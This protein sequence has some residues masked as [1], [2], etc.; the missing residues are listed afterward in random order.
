MNVTLPLSQ[1]EDV[2]GSRNENSVKE[3]S[4]LLID[5]LQVGTGGR[6]GL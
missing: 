5:F 1:L 2:M 3:R 6:W 4:R